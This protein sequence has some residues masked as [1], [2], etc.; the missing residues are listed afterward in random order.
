[1]KRKI[2]LCILCGTLL[3]GLVGCGNNSNE[4]E[5]SIE[6]KIAEEIAAKVAVDIKLDMSMSTQTNVTDVEIEDDTA[7]FR[8][9]YSGLGSDYGT[10]GTFKGTCTVKV[11]GDNVHISNLDFELD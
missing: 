5:E 11:S 7:T 6:D 9:R 2:L 10:S 1:M 3:L 4:P 8:G